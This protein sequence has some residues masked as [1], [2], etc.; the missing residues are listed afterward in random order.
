MKTLKP[1][2][3]DISAADYHADN[4]TPT[5]SLS[6]SLAK[7]MVSQ[8]PR[9]AWQESNRLNPQYVREEDTIFDIGTAIHDAIL[10]GIDRVDVIDANDWRTKAA[11]EARDLSRAQGRIPLLPK[12]YGRVKDSVQSAIAALADCTELGGVDLSK[13]VA[14]KTIYWED[15][16]TWC[17][18][19]PD[20]MMGSLI[21]DVKSCSG[22]VSPA[23]FGRQIINMG[24][25]IQAQFYRRGFSAVVGN[26]PQ[27]VFVAVEVEPP[28]AVSFHSLAPSLEALADEQVE[29]AIRAWADCLHNDRWPAYSRRIHYAEA[30]GYAAM[31]W[32]DRKYERSA[33]GMGMPMYEALFGDKDGLQNND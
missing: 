22:S 1:G 10:E 9:H 25:H 30:P 15:I 14:E 24:Y 8:S 12:V 26:E 28:Y 6:A 3:H 18:C 21:L 11:R 31:Q 7:T 2:F 33:A 13:G 20:W 27:F 5:A 4:I 23:S 19:R 16:G 17:R 32:D 29:Y